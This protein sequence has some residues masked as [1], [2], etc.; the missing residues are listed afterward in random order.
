MTEEEK[1]MIEKIENLR[2]KLDILFL[3]VVVVE[4]QLF[5]TVWA[6]MN[7]SGKP[8]LLL[9]WGFVALALAKLCI[10]K[11]SWK[12]WL[13]I[14]ALMVLGVLS[15][16]GSDDKTP[17][18][19]MLGVCMSKDVELDRLL[20]VDLICR[21]CSTCLLILLPVMGICENMVKVSRGISRYYFGWQ[22]PG[23]MGLAF[24]IICIE[25]MYFR[26]GQFKW[27]DYA[28]LVA[29]L[30]FLDRT[31]NSRSSEVLILGIFCVEA[32]MT[33]YRK[34]KLPWKEYQ[35]YGAGCLAALGL[36]LASFVFA[37]NYHMAENNTLMT[38]DKNFFSRYSLPRAF[39][40]VHGWTLLGSPYDPE[41]YDY[42][43][44]SFAYLSLHLGIL[45]AVAVFVL[46]AGSIVYGWKK[47]DVRFQLVLLFFLLRSI[48]ES[49][50]F[51]L[52]YAPLPIVLGIW[53]W[54][55]RQDGQIYE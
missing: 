46:F 15:W 28:G 19:L 48:V 34:L 9:Y 27:F 12:E 36:D 47:K 55:R 3:F 16:H 38:M 54:H 7:V 31:A 2:Q 14:A 33:V 20:K 10:Q 42:L 8:Y 1:Q 50:H 32:F 18:L 37:M 41:V 30:V 17:L 39:L 11:N 21:I 4:F 44:I 51:T 13:M 45:I 35:L 26:H 23:S 24:L 52:L 5:G 22:A 40:D 43:D 29:L 53:L 49:D 25:W 6:M